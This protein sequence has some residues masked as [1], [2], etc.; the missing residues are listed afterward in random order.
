MVIIQQRASKKLKEEVFS[1]M[2]F[3]YYF[4]F[5]CKVV[6]E[7]QNPALYSTDIILCPIFMRKKKSHYCSTS[8]NHKSLHSPHA[9]QFN[10]FILSVFKFPITLTSL[11]LPSHFSSLFKHFLSLCPRSAPLIP[12]VA[13]RRELGRHSFQG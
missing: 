5:F 12:L 7:F 10:K 8:P 9:L 6:T 2:F 1:E 3:P 13:P 4:F 11:A